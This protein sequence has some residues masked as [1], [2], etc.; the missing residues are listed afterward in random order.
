VL[1]IF[2]IQMR[3][4]PFRRRCTSLLTVIACGIYVWC[5]ELYEGYITKTAAAL[6]G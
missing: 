6:G 3:G 4:N 1:V 5:I 2:V